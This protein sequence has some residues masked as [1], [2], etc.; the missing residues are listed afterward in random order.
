MRRGYLSEYFEGVAM[1]RLSAVDAEPTR[2]NQHEVGTTPAIREY[3]GQQE[4]EF[5]AT[6]IWLSSEQESFSEAGT[7]T[8]YDSREKQAH[9]APEWR[10]YYPG[11]AVT[12][13]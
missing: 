10:L 5:P 12:E 11:N 8:L 4:R 2:S 9:R 13:A 6:F 1:K 7:L 3:L